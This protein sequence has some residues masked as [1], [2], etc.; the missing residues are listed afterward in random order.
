[1]G[2]PT[3]HPLHQIGRAAKNLGES[4]FGRILGAIVGE[5]PI[6]KAGR[7]AKE[8]GEILGGDPSDEDAM[9]EALKNATPEQ[10][11]AI[12]EAIARQTEATEATTRADIEAVTARHAADM[13]SD[14]P[15]SKNIR[16][17]MCVVL[18]SAAILYTYS[19]LLLFA[20]D[21]FLGAKSTL[22]SE[23]WEND[24]V[25]TAL[26]SLWA[27]AGGYNLFYI[28]WRGHEKATAMRSATLL[29]R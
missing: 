26:G 5:T 10:Q 7:V 23:F 25:K 24:L 27:A 21:Y 9:V 1:M 11:A 15:L 28:G 3:D 14:S 6:G 8:I 13:L 12:L 29:N 22:P 2:L 20:I 16:P 19:L 17:V 4:P 18:N